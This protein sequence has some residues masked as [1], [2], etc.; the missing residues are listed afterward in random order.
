L[1]LLLPPERLLKDLKL[2]MFDL[3][4]RQLPLLTN[5]PQ[6]LSSLLAAVIAESISHRPNEQLSFKSKPVYITSAY[7]AE[8]VQA[9]GLLSQPH[10]ATCRISLQ[11][12]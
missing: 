12:C 8:I 9:T 11:D 2:W 7:F 5:L 4:H 3:R 1:L 6:R 10:T